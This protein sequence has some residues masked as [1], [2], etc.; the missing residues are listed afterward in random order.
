MASNDA[1]QACQM[2]SI[3][4]DQKNELEALSH[5]VDG[6][7]MREDVIKTAL[8]LVAG[9]NTK[10]LVKFLGYLG[11]DKFSA[12]VAKTSVNLCYD[13]A[14]STGGLLRV[15]K[16]SLSAMA[17]DEKMVVAWFLVNICKRNADARSNAIVKS[18]AESLAASMTG[19]VIQSMITVILPGRATASTSKAATLPVNAMKSLES[20]RSLE[21]LHDNDFPLDFRRIAVLPTADELNKAQAVTGLVPIA[22][23][24]AALLDRQFRLLREDMLA[25]IIE[26]LNALRT[27]QSEKQPKTATVDKQQQRAAANQRKRLY[28]DPVLLDVT[29]DSKGRGPA[30][31]LMMVPIPGVM[32][33]RLQG[34]KARDRVTFLEGP[35]RRL[36]A[37]DSLL[38]F[39]NSAYAVQSVARVV[40]RESAEMLQYPGYL[41]VGV[42]FAP[43]HVNAALERTR[44]GQVEVV[45]TFYEQH[46]GAE[47]DDKN[48]KN[49]KNNK[50]KGGKSAASSQHQVQVVTQVYKFKPEEG[51]A[52]YVFQA[53]SS[54][55]SYEPILNCLQGMASV[56][57]SEELVQG[58]P[59][60]PLTPAVPLAKRVEGALQEDPNQRDAVE[61]ALQQ[62]LCLIQGPPGTGKT[63]VGVQIVRALL[64][65]AQKTG[66]EVRI[67]CLC[68]TNHALDD[69]L[70]SLH[71]DGKVPLA[72]MVRLGR[73]P[74]I[75]EK[76]Q[77]RCLDRLTVANGPDRLHNR[78]FAILKKEQE[79]CEEHA[80]W[81]K[82]KLFKAQRRPWSWSTAVSFFQHE[83]VQGEADLQQAFTELQADSRQ[84]AEG[85]WKAWCQGRAEPQGFYSSA[86]GGVWRLSRAD[87]DARLAE[88]ADYYTAILADALATDL[89]SFQRAGEEIV[90]LNSAKKV[91]A[92]SSAKIIG[93]TT[94]GAAKLRD[95]LA[96]L[97]P[98]MVLVEEAGEILEASV[99]TALG[100]SVKH[101]VMIGD[102]LQLRPKLECYRLR[103]E[104][105]QGINFDT[106]L[107]ER[108]ATQPGFPIITLN[109]QRRM[110][111]EICDLIR[112]TTYP[113]LKDHP[114]VVRRDELRGV[115][116]NVVF[117]DHNHPEGGDGEAAL[118]G[119]SSKTNSHEARMVCEMVRYFLAQG[120]SEGEIVVL[121]PYLGQL[122][123]IRDALLSAR[124]HVELNDLDRQELQRADI[125]VE[126]GHSTP[127][128]HAKATAGP[129]VEPAS[130]RVSTVD[131]YQGEESRVVIASLV[132]CNDRGEVGF[133]AGAERVNVM[134][135]RSRDGLVMIGSASTLRQARARKGCADWNGILD[136]LRARSCV[137]AGFPAY[138]DKHKVGPE[139]SVN[140][141]QLFAKWCPNGG[142]TR[143]CGAQILTCTQGHRC[144]LQ[145]HPSVDPVTKSDVHSTMLCK[146]LLPEK[147]KNGHDVKRV[148][149]EAE[150]TK[151]TA[152]VHVLCAAGLHP[153]PGHR[154]YQSVPK[155]CFACKQEAKKRAKAEEQLVRDRQAHSEKE[156]A[157]R[158]KLD[159]LAS[160]LDKVTVKRDHE[161]ALARMRQEQD[162]VQREIEKAKRKPPA[163]FLLATGDDAEPLPAPG[164]A[165]AEPASAEP[166]RPSLKSA[167]E[168]LK[169]ALQPAVG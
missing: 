81:L 87:R 146:T 65:H 123:V 165:V 112:L 8:N 162:L 155:D 30:C 18:I 93:C 137:H 51:F 158:A 97:R 109:E 67:L 28:P 119:T 139:E 35:G 82:A 167:G 24:E 125:D 66:E 104:S 135:S 44:F 108:L 50:E 113:E 129:V 63:Y 141:P 151:C 25:P 122:V 52:A 53:S 10:L 76:L 26:E 115:T 54:V 39:L 71:E 134:L 148:C 86:T 143:I 147:C 78:R 79:R 6:P 132:R 11:C 152:E 106:S 110:R 19:D 117:I 57:F 144:A 138:C 163:E 32:Q 150:A 46:A 74:K 102:H 61:R 37:K 88:W 5:L 157:E 160:A 9:E 94:T 100:P 136:H 23:H 98:T 80:Q 72:D 168:R 120:Y 83:V 107:F 2:I 1:G 17:T 55:F 68:Y 154:C 169:A 47:K 105:G 59:P 91:E 128:P 77:D 14:Y 70:L 126:D 85:R 62:R 42:E 118:F 69:F 124:T 56:P 159:E 114:S 4:V 75:H 73:S 103:N 92:A 21:P 27:D 34:M 116:G 166:T 145:C 133:V 22:G 31:V 38:L 7:K 140:S 90:L 130:V 161:Q 96:Q 48:D 41:C 121:T 127:N 84:D 89:A 29:V 60:L 131:N 45:K 111:T 58:H 15:L 13:L 16:N 153:I 12:G 49:H 33:A 101:C 64:V 156:A 20:L 164:S 99:L 3:I 36:L 95:V 149:C 43:S 40:R 142:C